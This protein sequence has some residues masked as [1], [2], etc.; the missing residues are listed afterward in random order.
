[1]LT[2][3]PLAFALVLQGYMK[4]ETSTLDF[5]SPDGHFRLHAALSSE[6]S[7]FADPPCTMTGKGAYELFKDDA[8]VWRREFDFA[9]DE[10]RVLSDGSVAGIGYGEIMARDQEAVRIVLITPNGTLRVDQRLGIELLGRD[11]L[12]CI[13]HARGWSIDEEQHRLTTWYWIVS[14]GREE[15]SAFD[16]TTGRPIP[17]RPRLDTNGAPFGCGGLAAIPGTGLTLIHA[18]IRAERPTLFRSTYALLDSSGKP[19]WTHRIDADHVEGEPGR[20]APGGNGIVG[21]EGGAKPSFRVRSFAD[22]KQVTFEL[23]Q[24]PTTKTWSVR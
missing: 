23:T 2:P 6:L 18:W 5:A 9:L 13:E 15:W 21:V 19:I 12:G 17:W 11:T 22:T 7:T 16:T 4:K 14:Q 10:A 20:A 8:S 1:M 24:D 3:I